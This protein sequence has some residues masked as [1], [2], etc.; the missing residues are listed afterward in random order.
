MN[1]SKPRFWLTL[2]VATLSL[3]IAGAGSAQ[4]GR[5]QGMTE[6]NVADEKEL[7]K[8]PHLNPSL[9]KGIVEHR[10]FANM[11]ELHK[12]LSP[13]L[14]SKQLNELYTKMFLQI[15]LNTAAREEIM[16]IPGMGNRMVREFLEYRPYTALTQFRKEIGKYVDDKEV[17]RLEQYV[18]VPINLNTASDE[19][20]SSIPGATPQLIRTIKDLRP[21]KDM[22]QF[23]REI[24]KSVD[25]K[26]AARLERYFVIN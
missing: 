11:M 4:V 23:R 12:F 9:V 20:L 5:H 10:P 17:A 13:S 24:A 18:F 1:K 7:V 14:E 25:A 15:D 3:S 26:E 2:A 8:L 21:Y 6:P 19:T 16:L 22:Q